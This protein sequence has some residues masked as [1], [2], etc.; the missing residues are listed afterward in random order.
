MQKGY[1]HALQHNEQNID[2]TFT[3]YHGANRTV[4]TM[5]PRRFDSSAA[6]ADFLRDKIGAHEDAR[7]DFLSQLASTRHGTMNEV[8]LSE[9]QRLQ[10]GL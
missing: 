8:W 5:K 4:R 10:L 7:Q 9:Q 3:A 6:L 2:L 1:L